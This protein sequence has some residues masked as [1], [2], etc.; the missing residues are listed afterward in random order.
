MLLRSIMQ[1]IE[2]SIW[3]IFFF[4][5]FFFAL[6][7]EDIILKFAPLQPAICWCVSRLLVIDL[8]Q[9]AIG[10]YEGLY[11]HIIGISWFHLIDW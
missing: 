1:R 4:L 3:Y 10:N 11:I 2:Q 8:L 7:D 5:F 6:G 9:P